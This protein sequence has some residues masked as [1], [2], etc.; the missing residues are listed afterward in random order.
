MEKSEKKMKKKKK[1]RKK[2]IEKKKIKK[3]NILMLLCCSHVCL[4]HDVGGST[5]VCST[6]LAYL[7]MKLDSP[8]TLMH[9]TSCKMSWFKYVPP[10]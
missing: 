7:G 9:W 8:A 6:A 2:E 3:N 10:A 5:L 1:M 4:T